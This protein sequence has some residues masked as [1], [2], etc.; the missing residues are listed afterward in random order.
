M[1]PTFSGRFMPLVASST[2]T[3]SPPSTYGAQRRHSPAVST[4]NTS[5]PHCWAQRR[6][7]PSTI[8]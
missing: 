2:I 5:L 3:P 6:A 4:S 1:G 7:S 8:T